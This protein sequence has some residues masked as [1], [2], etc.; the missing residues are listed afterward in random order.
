MNPADTVIQKCKKSFDLGGE[1]DSFYERL[2]QFIDEELNAIPNIENTQTSV[3]APVQAAGAV[4][5]L[6][7]VQAKKRA[8]T[9]YNNFVSKMC[10]EI[11]GM[12]N[13]DRMKEIGKRWKA[14]TDK[15]KEQY[16]N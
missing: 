10:S 2:R 12:S 11:T 8:P 15:E 13:A 3:Q 5:Q 9:P 7:Q 1:A 6:A 16:A 14:L 4:A